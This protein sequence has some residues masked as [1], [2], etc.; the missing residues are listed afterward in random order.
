MEVTDNFLENLHAACFVA[1]FLE[2]YDKMPVLGKVIS[3]GETH[4]KIHYWKGSYGGKWSPQ[5][6]PRRRTEPWLEDLP[7]SC[8][9]C[10]DFHLTEDNRLMPSTK[11]FLKNR[12]TVLR[13]NV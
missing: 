7:K 4:F 13:D 2:N 10:R 12:Y 9:V 3:V 5:N 11:T 8:I 1:V 6:I